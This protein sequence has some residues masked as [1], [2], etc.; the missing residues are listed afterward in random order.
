M[1]NAVSA[2]SGEGGE[3]EDA[4]KLGSSLGEAVTH[5]QQRQGHGGGN[6]RPRTNT[7]P[8]RAADDGPSRSGR[9]VSRAKARVE[10]QADR[11]EQQHPYIPM[12]VKNLGMERRN[13]V[14]VQA[15][16]MASIEAPGDLRPHD[17]FARIEELVMRVSNS[18][19]CHALLVSH[20]HGKLFRYAEP[21]ECDE[22]RASENIFHMSGGDDD[23][24]SCNSED[25][26]DQSLHVMICNVGDGPA[27]RAA[28][29]AQPVHAVDEDGGFILCWPVLHPEGPNM[30]SSMTLGGLPPAPILPREK[31][32]AVVVM[33]RSASMGAF[34]DDMLVPLPYLF[35]LIGSW[36]MRLLMSCEDEM[37]C[38]TA[39]AL[40][41]IS[42]IAPMGMDL[43]DLVDEIVQAAYHMTHAHR[44]C[45]FFVD[46][47]ANELWVARSSDLLGMKLPIGKGLCGYSAATGEVVN[48][49]D[50]YAEDRFD[51]EWDKLSG[52][53]TSTVLCVPIPPPDDS[54]D[55]DLA[56]VTGGRSRHG[57]FS[58][59]T[60][61]MRGKNRGSRGMGL[62]FSGS[63]KSASQVRRRPIAVL[64]V[65]NKHGGEVF[66][67]ADEEGLILLCAEVEGLLRPKAV[68]AT[69]MKRAIAER[70]R[71]SS[72]GKGRADSTH[73]L[74]SSI[75]SEYTH[76]GSLKPRSSQ[77]Q[78]ER[79]KS[80]SPRRLPSALDAKQA[81]L[82][83]WDFDPFKA[84]TELKCAMLEAMFRS[85]SALEELKIREEVLH[86]FIANVRLSYRPNPFHNFNHA[87]SVAHVS[88]MLFMEAGMS[89][90][91]SPLEM[92]ACLLA[93]YCHDIDHPGNNNAFEVRTG[94]DLALLYSDDAVLERHHVHMTFRLLRE[95]GGDSN[96]LGNLAEA[97]YQEAREVIIK[98]ILA[99]DMSRHIQHCSRLNRLAQRSK[100]MH[101]SSME[102]QP[103]TGSSGR[104]ANLG[105]FGAS[106]PAALMLKRTGH[107]GVFSSS[108][109]VAV[110]AP[111]TPSG[112]SHNHG[113]NFAGVERERIRPEG[114]ALRVEE[115][116]AA[117]LPVPPKTAAGAQ[118]RPP[119]IL[120]DDEG[121][122][123]ER[124][125][126][127]RPEDRIF[128]METVVHCAD[129][130]GQVLT[131]HLALEWGRRVLQEFRNQAAKEESLQLP[132]SFVRDSSDLE[133]MKGQIFFVNKIVAPLWEPFVEIF[134]ELSHLTA[135]MNKN[136]AYY[137]KEVQQGERSAHQ[138]GEGKGS[139]HP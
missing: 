63:G 47:Y 16:M 85:L 134:P 130:S 115:G 116:A 92:L 20:C 60:S 53:K 119:A 82:L 58:S 55:G 59:C 84:A 89:S 42:Q 25:V 122:H 23:I 28:L 103:S 30:K 3:E 44:V 7:Y 69:L 104:R 112:G 109:G 6:A 62:D 24:S 102:G 77:Y 34:T 26:D 18:S 110:S 96:I 93:A 17:L 48:V 36:V 4:P 81:A 108:Q 19:D 123:N 72:T 64:E 22:S 1:G 54:S 118:R 131:T 86:S 97:Q 45:L 111:T 128:L 13:S 88:W 21:F 38:R 11:L 12:L 137:S 46:E 94:S 91:L 27:G 71:A 56:S 70:A 139:P 66:D 39:E 79:P 61:H 8:L 15:V 75:L 98:T 113:A 40:L 10:G 52:Y 100:Q 35:S 106:G 32:L 126:T 31:V 73:A 49:P 135:N 87:F 107:A 14:G 50:C 95:E 37:R 57:S 51:P 41:S 80:L 76:G 121:Q 127:D 136:V 101:R 65:L 105:A 114:S 132:V 68:E 67:E 2:G 43:V 125:F 74:Q 129:L 33:K 29:T 9:K 138:D 133:Q 120:S 99:T 90:T 83:D 117:A 124:V 78:G 5:Y